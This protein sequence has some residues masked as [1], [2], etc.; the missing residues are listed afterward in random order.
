MFPVSRSRS[1]FRFK[2]SAVSAGDLWTPAQLTT[3]L[4]LD[5]ADAGT[6]T[7]NGS[8]VSQWDDKSGNSRNF[9]QAT[10]AN[11]P[12]YSAT[13]LGGKPALTFDGASDFMSAGDT[14]DVGTTNLTIMT[15]VKY[16]TD[17]QTGVIVGKSLAGPSGP[18]RYSLGRRLTSGGAFGTGSP[19]NSFL[20]E[21]QAVGA[22][23][24]VADSST[25]TKIIGG[26]WSRAVPNGYDK[27]WD[28]GTNTVTVPYAGDTATL[29]NTNELWIGAY[30]S[31]TG[32][33]PPTLGSYINGQIA[34]VVIA[35]SALSTDNRQKLEGYLAWK[36]G[37]QADLPFDHPYKNTPPTV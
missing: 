14:L 9:A 13:V 10:A 29:D 16:A 19:F 11:Q 2:S 28:N 18:G 26:E 21:G 23:A 4:W 12:T 31:P 32:T 15:V 20:V 34:E 27:V 36:W 35:L 17:N 1:R 30:Q 5:A 25:N 8:T 33:T 3:A 22:F 6:I 24:A 37:T 7:L